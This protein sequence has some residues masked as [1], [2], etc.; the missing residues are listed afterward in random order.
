M[1][2]N[3]TQEDRNVLIDFLKQ[4]AILTQ[5][6]QVKAFE[7]EWSEWLGVKYSVLVNSGS[8]AN[9]ATLNILKELYGGGEIIVS[10]LNW[11]SDIAA[12]LQN[13]FKPVFIDINP[14][15]LGMNDEQIIKKLSSDTRAVLLTHILGYNALSQKLLDA[16]KEKKIML[17]EDACESHGATFKNQKVG[18][19]GFASNFSFYF[20]HHMTTVE[21]GMIST[22]DEKFYET[23]RMMRSHGLVRELTS[24]EMKEGFVKKFPDLNPEFIFAFPAYNIRSTEINAVLGRNQLKRLNHEI[25]Q[26]NRNLVFFLNHLDAKKYRTDFAVEGCS[27]YA[28]T[29]ILKNPDQ[30]LCDR[31]MAS[32]REHGIEFRRGTSGGGNQL[33]QPYLRRLFGDEYQKYPEVD[34]VHFFG[35]YI[36]NYPVL[37]E[38]KIYKLC[39]LLNSL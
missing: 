16:L 24:T 23:A 6:Q 7:A 25:K 30:A 19:F 38:E 15:T 1:E 27:N 22:N 4:D 18:S 29:L 39:Q 32:L 8:S 3:I 11:V 5:N 12:V 33:R 34:H 14:K 37:G 26:R 21:G 9:L 35:F 36:G 13:G 17:I 20:A 10:P 2:N 28:L 31:V